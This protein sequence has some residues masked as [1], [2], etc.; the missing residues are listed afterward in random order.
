M[1]NGYLDVVARIVGTVSLDLE[2]GKALDLAQ[3]A[4]VSTATDRVGYNT[5][6]VQNVGETARTFAQWAVLDESTHAPCGAGCLRPCG[7]ATDRFTELPM[8]LAPSSSI[9]VTSFIV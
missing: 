8:R 6:D 3:M 7:V 9:E 5:A 1:G 2:A 4:G